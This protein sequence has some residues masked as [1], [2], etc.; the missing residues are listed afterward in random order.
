MDLQEQGGMI[1]DAFWQRMKGVQ[2]IHRRLYISGK[3]WIVGWLILLLTHSGRRTG[4]RYDTPLQFELIDGTYC[5]GAGR[6]VKADWFRNVQAHPDVH[7]RVGRREF[8]CTAEAVTDPQR[9][10]DFLAF[11]L[12]RHPMMI[13]L[14]MKF[15]HR[16]PM[17]PS[18]AQLLE[19]ASST[20]LVILRPPEGVA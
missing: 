18:R 7:V 3:G 9:V 4:K 8:D 16:L 19:L 17:R 13:G 1:P 2:R 10:A 20:A 14:M 5:V 6:G 11:R 15:A 12:A